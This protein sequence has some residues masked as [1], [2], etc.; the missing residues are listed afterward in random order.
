MVNGLQ[1]FQRHFAAFQDAYLLIGGCACDIHFEAFDLP[2]RTT[3]DLDIV[4]CVEA[5]S[6]DFLRTFWQF[7]RQGGYETRLR[8]SGGRQFYRF[9]KPAQ[10]DYPYMLELFSRQPGG[11]SLAEDV[12]LTPFGGKRASRFVQSALP[13]RKRRAPSGAVGG[14]GRRAEF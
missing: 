3:K 6:D 14:F 7:V 12:H 4:L 9:A 1:T 5:L 10:P 8:G 2:F 11:L 13:R